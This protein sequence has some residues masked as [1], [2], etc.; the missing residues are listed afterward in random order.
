MRIPACVLLLL[1]ASS[2]WGFAQHQH[3]THTHSSEGMAHKIDPAA[4]LEV[5]DDAAAHLLLVRVGPL[6]LPAQSSHHE[7]AQAAPQML[8][9]P[10]EG[11]FTAYHPVLVDGAGKTLPS[12]LLHHVAFWNAGRADFLCPNKPEHVFGAGGEMNDWPALP[13][14]GYR[15]HAGDQIRIDTM[16]HNPTAT[17]YPQVYLEVRV[18]YAPAGAK[19][20]SVYP[21]W[22]D[23]QSC[24]SSGYDLPAGHSVKTGEVKLE[25]SGK[26]LGLGG[27]LHDYGRGL[28]LQTSASKD[29]V[30]DLTA[31]LDGQGRILSMPVVMFTQTG[32]YKVHKGDVFH[33]SAVYENPTGHEIPEGAMG[34]VVGYLLP[35]NDRDLAGLKR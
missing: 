11:W 8:T 15:V 31:K 4:K 14:F 13:G 30:A 26:L 6:N 2:S 29:S 19:L 17:S 20:A 16:F 12:R 35:D 9:V 18:E 34:I 10:V 3:A 21:A 22:F 7:V 1:F 24:G 28:L 27:H 32:G 5:R 33:V 23:V 25:F